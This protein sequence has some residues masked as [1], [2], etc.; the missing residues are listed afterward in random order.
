MEEQ[1]L[2]T[3]RIHQRITLMLIENIPDE[4]LGATLSTR[5]ARDIARQLA[6]VHMVRSARL[7]S[8]YFFPTFIA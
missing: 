2:E 4:A 5:A 8:F 7:E 3:W 1:I 6:H